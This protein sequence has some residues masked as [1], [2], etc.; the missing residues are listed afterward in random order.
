MASSKEHPVP[1][2]LLESWEAANLNHSARAVAWDMCGD[3]PQGSSLDKKDSFVYR[4]LGLKHQ[5]ACPSARAQ[6]EAARP[7]GLSTWANS[8]CLCQYTQRIK[9]IIAGKIQEA[10]EPAHTSLVANKIQDANSSTN[11]PLFGSGGLAGI[12]DGP[13]LIPESICRNP[14]SEWSSSLVCAGDCVWL[15]N[16]EED[17]P[18]KSF[19]CWKTSCLG[20]WISKDD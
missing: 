7:H 8:S 15:T 20:T 4:G 12:S 17:Q 3:G 13:P 2:S 5:Y 16:H 1:R 10:E 18:V 19:M 11:A 9:L 6:G 14:Y